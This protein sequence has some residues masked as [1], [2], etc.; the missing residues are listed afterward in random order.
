MTPAPPTPAEP[1]AAPSS[2]PRPGRDAGSTTGPPSHPEPTK[3]GEPATE[4]MSGAG[5]WA[6]LSL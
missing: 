3:A 4:S 5:R 1:A 6:V 2:R